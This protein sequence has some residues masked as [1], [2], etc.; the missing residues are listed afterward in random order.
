MEV[1]KAEAEERRLAHER[2]VAELRRALEEQ[3]SLMAAAQAQLARDRAAHEAE[4]QA[5]AAAEQAATERKK[6]QEILER[7]RVQEEEAKKEAER[8]EQEQRLMDLQNQE[9]ENKNKE[10][11][12][13]E[14]TK[15]VRA[16]H[17][18]RIARS[19]QTATVLTHVCACLPCLQR[20]ADLEAAKVRK[21][22]ELQ[23]LREAKKKEE[24][25]KNKKT[26]SVPGLDG[27]RAMHKEIA[28]VADF[29]FVLLLLLSM[30]GQ[31]GAARQG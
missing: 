21:Q 4:V 6:A 27:D 17:G 15:K 28:H 9:E 18:S 24:A 20:Q 3:E 13:E 14:E 31:L 1:L 16:A 5:L 22:N 11:Q 10:L 7:K 8:Y 25:E 30:Q 2:E 23:R 19:I 26:M 12:R 29:F